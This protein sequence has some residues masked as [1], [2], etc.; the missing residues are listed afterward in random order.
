[1][2]PNQRPNT[3]QHQVKELTEAAQAEGAR[4]PALLRGSAAPLVSGVD[5]L[6]QLEKWREK[7]SDEP[8]ATWELG[9]QVM[10]DHWI[11]RAAL[12]WGWEE[13]R[14]LRGPDFEA[15]MTQ[16]REALLPETSPDFGFGTKRK[17]DEAQESAAAYAEELEAAVEAA[18]WENDAL[19][20][21]VC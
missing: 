2:H 10:L 17:G 14:Y 15:E 19:K 16:L 21:Q 3:P 4:V 8:W 18:D 13:E 9:Q 1:M 11:C 6:A 7:L 5:R 12:G 20:E